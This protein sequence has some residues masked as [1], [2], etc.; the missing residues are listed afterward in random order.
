M[1]LLLAVQMKNPGI[2][3]RISGAETEGSRIVLLQWE[4]GE[5]VERAASKYTDFQ[6]TGADLLARTAL[7]PGAAVVASVI[8]QPAGLFKE[9]VSRLVLLSLE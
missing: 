1:P 2:L 8:E 6:F 5:F 3:S 7:R 4:D 9:R